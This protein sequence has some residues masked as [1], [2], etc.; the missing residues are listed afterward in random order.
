MPTWFNRIFNRI[1]GVSEAPSIA[2]AD[3]KKVRIKRVGYAFVRGGGGGGR[4]QFEGPEFDLED[5]ERAYNTDSYV[6]QALDKYTELMFKAGWALTGK[7]E[8]AIEYIRLRLEMMAIATGQPVDEFFIEVAESLVKYANVFIV[9]A[10][11]KPGQGVNVP[12]VKAVGITGD[13][14]IAGYFVLPPTT[15]E[16]AR[17]LNGRI[18]K[19]QQRV[20]GANKPLEFKP[21]DMVHIYYKREHGKAYGVPFV[22]PVLDD[23]RLLRDVEENVSRLL[24]RHLHPLYMYQVGLPQAGF[25]ATDEEIE[26]VR[27]EIEDM[28]TDGGIVLPERHKIEA[29]GAEGE[30]IDA[31]KYLEYYE[32]RV[33]TGLG[34]SQVVM[35]RGNTANRGTADN[36]TTEMHDRIK[37][38]QKVYSIGINNH[39]IDEL[40]MEGGFDPVL[41]PD[42]DVIFMFKEIALDEKI[43]LENHEILKFTQ[44]GQTFEEMRLNIGADPVVDESR[45]FFNM[46]QKVLAEVQAEARSN[47]QAQNRATPTNQHGT[48]TSPKRAASAEEPLQVTE[49]HHYKTGLG[50][51]KYEDRLQYHYE[52]ARQDVI[53]L[54]KQYYIKGNKRFPN[55]QPREI[56]MILKLTAENMHNTSSQYIANA[57]DLGI[58]DARKELGV[59]RVGNLNRKLHLNQLKDHLNEDVDRLIN[60]IAKFVSKAIRT[61]TKEDAVAKVTG[62]FRSLEYRIRFMSKSQLMKAYNYG[63]AISGQALDRDEV[64]VKL[65]DDESDCE[66]CTSHLESPIKLS[67]NLFN[68]IPPWHPNCACKLTYNQPE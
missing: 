63:F 16:I 2:K 13:Q 14:P 23:V 1:I 48:K 68:K 44:N 61:S 3:P 19:Y 27:A 37:A 32:N 34:V 4:A 5:I 36:M 45:L 35:G 60:D 42:D 49:A 28:P 62:T 43:K 66:E 7:N 39:I 64:Y 20:A 58:K 22:I 11:Q 9:K 50:I 8:R 38:I 29:I 54:V 18:V 12:G 33:F 55:H 24:Y 26:A 21:E 57:F 6:R 59:S 40:L 52:S 46:I 47:A 67:G 56:E 53:A 10:R 17:D 15:I 51:A 25:E 31:S 65:G 30:A 41:R